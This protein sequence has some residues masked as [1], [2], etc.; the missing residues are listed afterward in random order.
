MLC[1]PLADIRCV[2]SSYHR[3]C[4]MRLQDKPQSPV[5]YAISASSVT[6]LIHDDLSQ[7]FSVVLA[8]ATA[9]GESLNALLDERRSVQLSGIMLTEKTEVKICLSRS[10]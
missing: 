3:D 10:T 6:T 5:L 7:V 8:T 9:Q 1:V 4:P 2:Q